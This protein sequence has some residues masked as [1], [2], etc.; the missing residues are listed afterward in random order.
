MYVGRVQNSFK[1]NRA[2]TPLKA[3]YAGYI[4]KEDIKESKQ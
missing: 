2:E 4:K 3:T 1:S